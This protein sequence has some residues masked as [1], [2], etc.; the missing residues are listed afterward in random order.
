VEQTRAILREWENLGP[1]T[2][3]ILY[4]DPA[5]RQQVGD[6]MISLKTWAESPNPSGTG[7]INATM[8]AIKPYF[9]MTAGAASGVGATATLPGALATQLLAS[10]GNLALHSTRLAKMLTEGL[11]TPKRGPLRTV[12]LTGEAGIAASQAVAPPSSTPTIGPDKAR[13][14]ARQEIS[15]QVGRDPSEAEIDRFLKKYPYQGQ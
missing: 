5:V 6:F 14:W 9:Q 1:K 4:P 2:K 13:A 15:S 10:G 12:G 7:A 11:T 3:E 8:Q